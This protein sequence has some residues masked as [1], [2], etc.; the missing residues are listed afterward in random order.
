[1]GTGVG[2]KNK[3]NSC[4][5]KCQ[6]KKIHTKK[7]VKKNSCKEKGKKKNHSEGRSNCDFSHVVKKIRAEGFT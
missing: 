1:M 7:K 3:K 2:K 6:E 5:G 4:K